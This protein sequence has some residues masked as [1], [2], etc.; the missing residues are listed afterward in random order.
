VH[1]HLRVRS[2]NAPTVPGARGFVRRALLLLLAPLVMSGL[3]VVASGPDEAA[4]ASAPPVR[5]TLTASIEPGDVLGGALALFDSLRSGANSYRCRKNPQL[6][7]CDQ[8]G[9]GDILRGLAS[10]AQVNHEEVMD[11]LVKIS[12]QIDQLKGLTEEVRKKLD[13]TSY[14]TVVNFIGAASVES[15]LKT[16]RSVAAACSGKAVPYQDTY[17]RIE[18][19]NDTTADPGQLRTQIRGLLNAGKVEDVLRKVGGDAASGS[20]GVLTQLPEVV[21]NLALDNRFF[22]SRDAQVLANRVKYFVNLEEGVILLATNYWRWEGKPANEVDASDEQY[23]NAVVAQLELFKP[24]PAD[25]VVDMRTGLM[26]TTTNNCLK[27]SREAPACPTP[28]GS[29]PLRPCNP[30]LEVASCGS[31]LSV[32]VDGPNADWVRL[33]IASMSQTGTAAAGGWRVPTLDTL[34]KLL[35]GRGT[36]V[37]GVSWLR[38]KGTITVGSQYAWTS[39]A[40]CATSIGILPGLR[41]VRCGLTQRKVF[42]LNDATSATSYSDACGGQGCGAFYMFERPLSGQELANNPWGVRKRW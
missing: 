40:G 37:N 42:N 12:G 36:G 20:T 41:S 30:P 22:T 4:A 3:L 14:D 18:L 7:G 28:S 17:C 21:S 1:G 32:P 13:Q 23:Q 6:D 35:N 38:D 11:Q 5:A 15:A 16:L 2:P 24:L 9:L 10:E 31:I 39:D 25:V 27:T 29:P 34:E 8:A 19:G 26:W 33:Y